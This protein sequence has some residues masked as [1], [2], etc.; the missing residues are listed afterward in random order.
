MKI[1]L[2]EASNE[3]VTWETAVDIPAASLGR[4]ELLS[5]EPVIWRG[6][7]FAVEGGF[8]LRAR[9][10]TSQGLQCD[11][12][13]TTFDHELISDIELMVVAQ[14]EE[15]D[16]E[17]EL[18]ADDLGLLYVEGEFLDTQPLM[19]EHLQLGVPM[20]PICR[21]ECQ[22]LCAGCGA[23]LNDGSCSCEGSSPDP[24]WAALGELK[25]RL[26]EG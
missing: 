19:L 10:E 5:L 7:V 17:V 9:L 15:P 20:K 24:R 11:R 16:L 13:L 25:G 1:R 3:P 4:S 2:E 22:G 6:R 23:D 14:D 8:L 12:C 21:S 18:R 26:P